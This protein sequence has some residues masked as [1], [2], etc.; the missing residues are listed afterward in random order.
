MIDGEDGKVLVPKGRYAKMRNVWFI[1]SV[2]TLENWLKR[3]GFK[4]IKLCHVD[5]TSTEEQR[6]TPWMD[7][8]SLQQFLDPAD[9]S[10]TIEGYPAPKRALFVCSR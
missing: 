6:V 4:D 8:E 7:Y 2:L 10:K 5:Y 1:P 9:K 3:C